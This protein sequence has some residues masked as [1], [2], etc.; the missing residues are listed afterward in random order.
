MDI[1]YTDRYLEKNYIY[2]INEYIYTLDKKYKLNKNIYEI[3]E[4]TKEKMEKHLIANNKLLIDLLEAIEI[5][6]NKSG[7]RLLKYKYYFLYK[8]KNLIVIPL[9]SYWQNNVPFDLIIEYKDGAF[10]NININ[11]MPKIQLNKGIYDIREKKYKN[12]K[13]KNIKIL[14][15]DELLKEKKEKEF[16]ELMRHCIAKDINYEISCINAGSVYDSWCKKD[17]E[18]PFY[19]DITPTKG[20]CNI[21]TGECEMPRG[22]KRIGY[23]YYDYNSQPKC[24]DKENKLY[25]CGKNDSNYKWIVGL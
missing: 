17:D 18:C 1:I 14:N 11:R 15:S 13:L 16:A 3:G 20:K 12:N 21:N 4:K 5:K 9:D 10:F 22:I 6:I 19:K 7:R 2:L 23:T 25:D 8:E 24:I